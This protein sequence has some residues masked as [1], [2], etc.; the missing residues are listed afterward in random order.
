[1]GLPDLSAFALS[2]F[3]FTRMADLSDTVALVR[4]ASP[5]SAAIFLLINTM[6]VLAVRFKADLPALA[7]GGARVPRRS[8]VL[9]QG[10]FLV[11]VA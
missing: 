5:T 1:M 4:M 7:P 2:G 9:Q 6:L 8:I 3:P 11:D 10:Q